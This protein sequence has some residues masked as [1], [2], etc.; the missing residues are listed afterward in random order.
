MAALAEVKAA[1]DECGT[2]GR[3]RPA[4]RYG[5]ALSSEM[6]SETRLAENK[7]PRNAFHFERLKVIG[8][9]GVGGSMIPINLTAAT[10]CSNLGVLELV[11]AH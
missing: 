8:H 5:R 7:K 6:R 10:S 9:S 1:F 3:S 11:C 4:E 2:K